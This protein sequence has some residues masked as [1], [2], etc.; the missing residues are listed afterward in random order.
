MINSPNHPSTYNPNHTCNWTIVVPPSEHVVLQFES[1]STEEGFDELQ[2][3]DGPNRN[4][5]IIGTL[6]GSSIPSAIYSTRNSM[7]LEF[8]T[9]HE[10]KNSSFPLQGFKIKYSRKGNAKPNV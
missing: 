10:N 9:D 3:F 7:F 1:F 8:A 4:S 5:A 6:S 2:V